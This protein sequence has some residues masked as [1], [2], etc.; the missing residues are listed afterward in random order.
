MPIIEEYGA[1]ARR[2]RELKTAAPKSA[3]EIAELE[4]WRDLARQTAREYVENRRRGIA[5]RAGRPILPHPTD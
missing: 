2:L 4:R 3:D 5:G 1:I